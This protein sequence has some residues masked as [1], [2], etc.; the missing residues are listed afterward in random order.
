MLHRYKCDFKRKYRILGRAPFPFSFKK[1]G[2]GQGDGFSYFFFAFFFFF[3][4][5]LTVFFFATA[6]GAHM[7]AA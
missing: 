6:L 3:A 5:F 1:K 4:A 7:H 2:R